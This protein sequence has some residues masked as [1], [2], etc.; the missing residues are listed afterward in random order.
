MTTV[1]NRIGLMR[2]L[3]TWS[4]GNCTIRWTNERLEQQ[5]LRLFQAAQGSLRLSE[6]GCEILPDWATGALFLVP[7]TA[8]LTADAQAGT[9]GG[10]PS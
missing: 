10:W 1:A 7:T 4:T 8:E 3:G 9:S 6:A 2:R 5:R